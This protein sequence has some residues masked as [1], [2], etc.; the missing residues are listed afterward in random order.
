MN[1]CEQRN[2][3]GTESS[4]SPHRQVDAGERGSWEKKEQEQSHEVIVILNFDTGAAGVDCCPLS[5]GG[6]SAPAP[7]YEDSQL[8]WSFSST[9]TEKLN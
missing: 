3:S 1:W 4:Q 8:L 2:G 7:C 5:T 6:K 9:T